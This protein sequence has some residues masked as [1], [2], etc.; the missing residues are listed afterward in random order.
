MGGTLVVDGIAFLP[1]GTTVKVGSAGD[2][3]QGTHRNEH[4]REGHAAAP[5]P[6][7]HRHGCNGPS[8]DGAVVVGPVTAQRHHQHHADAQQ[9]HPD[10]AAALMPILHH[11][12]DAARQAHQP[13]G[14]QRVH[15]I[16]KPDEHCHSRRFKPPW[17]HFVG[18][19]PI[20]S[21]PVQEHG[22]AQL[23]GCPHLDGIELEL[24]EDQL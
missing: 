10:D 21:P 18:L 5:Q 1:Q 24:G 7:Q 16:Y 3:P 23:D 6:P 11:D 15:S 9:S 20:V 8:D 12:H 17:E 4:Q 19:Q 2:H 13:H 22:D 14:L